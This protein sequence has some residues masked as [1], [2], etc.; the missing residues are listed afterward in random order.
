MKIL[1]RKVDPIKYEKFLSIVMEKAG[2]SAEHAAITAKVMITNEKL[3]I[4]THGSYH[5]LTYI[6]K[7]QTG[8][9]DPKAIPEVIKE[10]PS[11]AVM[12]AHDCLGMVASWK[13]MDLAIEK[14]SKVGISYVGVIESSHF[15]S[16]ACFALKAAEK[17]MIGMAMTNT[18]KNMAV[19][20]SRGKVIGNAPLGYALPAK[21]HYPVFF[22]VA[23]SVA[24][25][26]KILRSVESGQLLP[27]GWIVDEKGRPTRDPNTTNFSMLP[28]AGHK[29][30]GF[31]FFIE[32]MTGILTGG[33]FLGGVAPDWMQNYPV[34]NK[35]N[36]AFMVIDPSFII[37]KEAYAERI[38]MAIDELHNSPV[39]EGSSRIYVPGE[40]EMEN[41]ARAE[42]EGVVLGDVLL[43]NMQEVCTILDLNMDDV[44]L[45]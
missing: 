23:T 35:A 21:K 22:D 7:M 25:L 41:K 11:Y 19:P 2:M 30:Y 36:H 26:T 1:S 15:G 14:A 28:F 29:G 9:I 17:G 43:K 6:K 8:G 10:G 45:D 20:G 5:T 33:T 13:A 37:G 34:K 12:N 24:A 40:I 42:R 3:G 44:F 4:S 18:F 38:D 27:E 31:A 16:C 39:A 32:A